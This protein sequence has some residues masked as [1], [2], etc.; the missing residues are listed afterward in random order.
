MKNPVERL[1]W[2]IEC[3]E[4]SKRELLDK[5][6]RGIVEYEEMK[7]EV[8]RIDFTIFELDCELYDLLNKGECC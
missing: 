7:K 4:I 6:H 1:Q 5:Y 8:A 3:L 2:S